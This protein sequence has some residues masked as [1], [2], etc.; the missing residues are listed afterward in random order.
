MESAS[1]PGFRQTDIAISGAGGFIGRHLVA[2]LRHLGHRVR[3]LCRGDGGALLPPDGV[4]RFGVERCDAVIH[5][6]FPVDPAIRRADPERTR[7]EVANAA[8]SAVRIA[9][10]LQ[11]PRVLLAS[12]GKAY[13][14]PSELPLRDASPAQPNTLLGKLKRHA[15]RVLEQEAAGTG[16]TA[17][18]LRI[19]NCYGPGQSAGFLIPKLVEGWRTGE[20]RLGELGHARDWIHVNDVVSAFVTALGMSPE[21]GRLVPLGVGTGRA[22]DPRGL[23]EILEDAGLRLP[24][25]IVDP[26][27]LRPDEPPEERAASD[28]LRSA[29]WEPETPLET[30]LPALFE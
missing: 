24:L 26:S 2:R 3:P 17:Y 8:A 20:L 4:E 19:F 7:E 27:L 16:V 5:L 30:G 23:L 12:S 1:R 21:P 22:V 25:P 10:R 9:R 15:E 6:A 13:G 29:G 28:G 14:P 18:S 11:A